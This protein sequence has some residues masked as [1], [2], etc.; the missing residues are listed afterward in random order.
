MNE[1][2]NKRGKTLWM[3]NLFG[4]LS[5]DLVLPC[6]C[7]GNHESVARTRPAENIRAWNYAW[8][9]RTKVMPDNPE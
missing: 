3:T 1:K 5:V 4:Q 6:F 7:V 9:S 8:V 2:S